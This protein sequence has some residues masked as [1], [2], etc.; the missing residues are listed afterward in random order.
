MF[1]SIQH[2]L[3]FINVVSVYFLISPYVG[4]SLPS[5]YQQQSNPSLCPI[6]LHSVWAYRSANMKPSATILLCFW[7]VKNSYWTHSMLH[8]LWLFFSFGR[9]FGVCVCCLWCFL[10]CNSWKQ[11]KKFEPR[12]FSSEGFWVSAWER[13]DAHSRRRSYP[14]WRSES[15]NL[16]RQV[17]THSPVHLRLTLIYYQLNKIQTNRNVQSLVCEMPIVLSLDLL[18]FHGDIYMYIIYFS[19]QSVIFIPEALLLH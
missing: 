4:S 9:H 19:H 3:I 18:I 2:T 11:T 14:Q 12:C 8:H 6:I 17:A 13:Q 7:Q 1:L 15:Q 5:C 16:P 10:S